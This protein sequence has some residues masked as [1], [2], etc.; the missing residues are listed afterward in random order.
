MMNKMFTIALVLCLIQSAFNVY[1]LRK[2]SLEEVQKANDLDNPTNPYKHG[3]VYELSS[4][5]QFLRNQNRQDTYDIHVMWPS[6]VEVKSV[7]DAYAPACAAG[8][9]DS[10]DWTRTD[11]FVPWPVLK[12]ANMEQLVGTEHNWS[13]YFCQDTSKKD[14]FDGLNYSPSVLNWMVNR[15]I[16]Y[17]E[18]NDD[19][20]NLDNLFQKL[21][22]YRYET[23]PQIGDLKPLKEQVW[24]ESITQNEMGLRESLSPGE[25]F[26]LAWA[27]WD[28][29]RT[30][31]TRTLYEVTEVSKTRGGI[32]VCPDSNRY[33]VGEIISGNT[34]T[35]YL[36]CVDGMAEVKNDDGTDRMSLLDDSPA[37][38]PFSSYGVTCF[39]TQVPM[40]T[41]K[42]KDV[43]R[44]QIDVKWTTSVQMNT[45]G[46]G[47]DCDNESA[48]YLTHKKRREEK[49]YDCNNYTEYPSISP[50]IKSLKENWDLSKEFKIVYRFFN[51]LGVEI[52]AGETGPVM[53]EYQCDRIHL[54]AFIL[55]NDGEHGPYEADGASSFKKFPFLCHAKVCPQWPDVTCKDNC[56]DEELCIH[57]MYN[58]ISTANYMFAMTTDQINRAYAQLLDK[59]QNRVYELKFN[60]VKKFD[61]AGEPVCNLDFETGNTLVK[62]L[63]TCE[64]TQSTDSPWKKFCQIADSSNTCD[65]C[66][67]GYTRL[68]NKTCIGGSD[69]EPRPCTNGSTYCKLD[70]NGTEVSM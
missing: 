19:F 30:E 25:L 61:D 31:N 55:D 4:T 58:G 62:G 16:K 40:V 15:H 48:E 24:T 52:L 32:C 56:Y 29:T 47:R 45:K 34:G 69:D 36:K 33:E 39:V 23:G 22:N 63:K 41:Y 49:D 7:H 11:I 65:V 13:N 9:S 68:S 8:A 67:Q 59:A 21:D 64:S 26:S 27:R 66:Y 12:M 37:G 54:N 6:R 1:T 2:F 70:S 14:F 51:W 42:Y 50:G 46:D 17:L 60:G 3:Q 43:R 5:K 35:G 53:F 20:D 38:K 28:H 44:A 10:P 57:N 18:D